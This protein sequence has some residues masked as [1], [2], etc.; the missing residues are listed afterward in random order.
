MKKLNLTPRLG[1]VLAALALLATAGAALAAT[2]SYQCA[3]CGYIATYSMPSP[4]ARCPS[5]G[6]A[7]MMK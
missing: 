2:Y 1:I 6:T 7:M 3:K 5:D 4:G